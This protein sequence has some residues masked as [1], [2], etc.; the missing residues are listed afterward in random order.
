MSLDSW[1]LF[2]AVSLLPAISPGPGV[3]LAI[4]NALRFGNR[5]AGGIGSGG[6]I[7]LV[8]LGY[9]V[10]MGLGVLMI[11]SAL[12]FTVVKLIGAVYLVYLVYLGVKLFRDKSAFV[13]VENANAPRQSYWQLFS[14]GLIISVTNPKA[15][16]VIA[17]LF[18]QF[19][20]HGTYNLADVSILSF[21]YAVL[22]FLNHALLA[23]FGGKIRKVL[24][25]QKTITRI[26]K[27]LGV[28]FVGFGA[29]L[30]SVSR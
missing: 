5:D 16:F 24:K 14:T 11:T 26:R 25:T 4:S 13:A 21:T 22:C 23:M 2:M 9:A 30:A 15:I 27:S 19:L 20:V 28:A 29:A 6:A 17:A 18:P 1:L 3:L 8:I 10:T 12:A 7:G